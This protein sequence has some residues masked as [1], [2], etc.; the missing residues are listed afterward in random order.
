MAIH[1]D[2]HGRRPRFVWQSS[3]PTIKIATLHAPEPLARRAA[4]KAPP[5]ALPNVVSTALPVSP[6]SRPAAWY[7]ALR[8]PAKLAAYLRPFANGPPSRG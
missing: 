5:P 4:D 7:M 3:E 6:W 2:E 8:H 1:G